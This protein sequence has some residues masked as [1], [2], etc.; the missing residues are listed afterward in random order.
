MKLGF[1]ILKMLLQFIQLAL[2]LLLCCSF[3]LTGNVKEKE[4]GRRDTND[5]RYLVGIRLGLADRPFHFKGHFG[6]HIGLACGVT[7]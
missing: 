7:G 6:F 5:G 3:P 2:K 4:E 1:R